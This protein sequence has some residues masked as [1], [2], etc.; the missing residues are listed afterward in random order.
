MPFKRTFTLIELLVVI[1]VISILI[2]LL[3]PGLQRAKNTAQ[4]AACQAKLK[5]MGTAMTLYRLDFD[6]WV[7]PARHGWY[8]KGADCKRT[9][10]WV[11]RINLYFGLDVNGP[12]WGD[13]LNGTRAG[14]NPFFCDGEP[15]RLWPDHYLSSYWIGDCWGIRGTYN[16][17]CGLGIWA[18]I[19]DGTHEP[20]ATLSVSQPTRLSSDVT[21]LAVNSTMEHGAQVFR[22]DQIATSGSPTTVGGP[23]VF[24]LPEGTTVDN[25]HLFIADTGNSQV[26]VWED[27]A[28]ALAGR[29][30][31]VILGAS[32]PSDTQPEIS[33][34]QM[35]WPAAA[36][37]D[38]TYLW[39]GE[40]KFSGR[41][42]R[43]SPTG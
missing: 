24:N 12:Q 38:G 29:S 26:L 16:M 11:Y 32:G 25:G 30:A 6:S 8:P 33:R 21:W 5:S 2:A 22:V 28:D 40:R 23:G 7:P 37:F 20:V 34:N 10:D 36:S 13:G 18:G 43:F 17:N 1:V 31:D 35:F 4:S 41:L 42:I 19:P 3:L 27:V 15:D 9:Y 14:S 39:V